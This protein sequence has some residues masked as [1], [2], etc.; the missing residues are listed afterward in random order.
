MT[1]TTVGSSSLVVG[2]LALA[3][4]SATLSS[5]QTTVPPGDTYLCY[6]AGLA[7]GQEKFTRSQKTL[8]DEFGTLVVDVKKIVTLCNPAQTAEHP[9]VHGVGYKFAPAKSVEQAKFVKADHTAI[10]QFGTH[11]LTLVKPLELR[12]PSATVLGPGGT[13]LVDTTGV[14]HFECYKA[15]PAKGAPK[16]VR[17]EP[18]AITDAFGTQSYTLKKLTKLCTPVNKNGEDVTAPQHV[19]HL[20]C[21][22]AKTTPKAKF[23]KQTVSVN[24]TNFGPAVL[25]AKAVSEVC[26]PAFLDTVPVPTPTPTPTTCSVE[27]PCPGGVECCS[28]TCLPPDAICRGL[29]SVNTDVQCREDADCELPKCS[30]IPPF[31]QTC[32]PRQIFP[33][34]CAGAGTCLTGSETCC[35]GAGECC[36]NDDQRCSAGQCQAK[37]PSGSFACGSETPLVC[38]LNA[39]N[40]TA[41]ACKTSCG[42]TTCDV[43]TET[44]CGDVCCDTATQICGPQPGTCVARQTCT[45]SDVY[46]PSRDVCCAQIATCGGNSACCVLALENCDIATGQCVPK[47]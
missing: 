23:T 33:N 17:P 2:L 3:T 22:R 41:G 26:V 18:L 21:Y 29:C 32:G 28:G 20:A 44:C 36:R 43:D 12:A 42:P 47:P 25:L 46:I 15:V 1:R 19:G 45:G 13:G 16:F 14:D 38:C 37:C 27:Q 39:Q 30:C 7:K 24:N 31:G 35:P 5:A 9:A 6:K 34:L 11:L 40:C 4:L 8:E 10:D